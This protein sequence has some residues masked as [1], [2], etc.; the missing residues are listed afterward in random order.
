MEGV[1][2][3]VSFIGMQ[4]DLPEMVT[5]SSLLTGGAPGTHPI[6]KVVT[7]RNGSYNLLVEPITTE[8]MGTASSSPAVIVKV[9]NAISQCHYDCSFNFID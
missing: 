4:G 2:W 8:F 9:N 1:S 6:A 5:D 3:Y 7:L